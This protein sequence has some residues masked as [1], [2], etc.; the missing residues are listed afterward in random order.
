M[1]QQMPKTSRL[2]TARRRRALL[3]RY[4][5][6]TFLISSSLR[7]KSLRREIVLRKSPLRIFQ[8][9]RSVL[10]LT[11]IKELHLPNE[12][13]CSPTRLQVKSYRPTKKKSGTYPTA[14][15]SQ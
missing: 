1:E 13:E 2:I 14:K 5:L 8:A 7:Q 11:V 15:T 4:P 3:L 12:P 6:K 9:L 10:V